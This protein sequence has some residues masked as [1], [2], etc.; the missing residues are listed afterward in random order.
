MG[1]QIDDFPESFSEGS[2]PDCCRQ[3]IAINTFS[4]TYCRSARF[5]SISNSILPRALFDGFLGWS[6]AVYTPGHGSI[7]L[8]L[9]FLDIHISILPPT[10][11]KFATLSSAVLVS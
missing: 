4:P 10:P 1:T 8:G 7:F 3:V 2:C 5:H 11:S 6:D 9:L